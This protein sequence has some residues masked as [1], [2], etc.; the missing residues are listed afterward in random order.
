MIRRLALPF[1]LFLIACSAT[2]AVPLPRRNETG[3]F[4]RKLNLFSKLRWKSK[5]QA[6][7]LSTA[8]SAPSVRLAPYTVAPPPFAYRPYPSFALTSPSIRHMTYYPTPYFMSSDGLAGRRVA[9]PSRHMPYAVPAMSAYYPLGALAGSSLLDTSMQAA[10]A[11]S[12]VNRYSPPLPLVGGSSF[13][14]PSA[15]FDDSI[16]AASLASILKRYLKSSKKSKYTSDAFKPDF[17]GYGY[18][19]RLDVIPRLKLASSR[20][21]RPRDRRVK[22]YYDYER[23]LESRSPSLPMDDGSR[24]EGHS[25]AETALTTPSLPY[26]GDRGAKDAMSESYVDVYGWRGGTRGEG[27]GGSSDGDTGRSSFEKKADA[28]DKRTPQ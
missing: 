20:T 14:P 18:S 19:P 22:D 12:F 27:D 1:L 16:D 25:S 15:L 4:L 28:G 6:S 10:L 7:D 21:P 23:P 24:L 3:T 8:D 11:S 26:Y 2:V 13:L 5:E 9:M 17:D